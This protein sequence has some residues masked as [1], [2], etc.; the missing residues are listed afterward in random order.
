MIVLMT[1]PCLMKVQGVLHS[2][3]K[4]IASLYHDPA[5]FVQGQQFPT[6]RGVKQGDNL[7]LLLFDAGLEYAMNNWKFCVEHCGLHCGDD[8]MVT[9]VHY[10]DDLMLYTKN[11]TDIA[12]MVERSVEEIA[13]VGSHLNISNTNILTIQ[14]SKAPV[15]LHT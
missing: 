2:G 6:K 15:F 10:A 8:E 4:L 7:S 1:M 5:G 12:N 9:N 11:G 14:N 13:T 3:L